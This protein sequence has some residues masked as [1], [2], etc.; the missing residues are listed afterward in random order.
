[1]R[2][3]V[4]WLLSTAHRGG[5]AVRLPHLD[6]RTGGHRAGT[7]GRQPGDREHHD[8]LGGSV[9]GG[10]GRS[11]RAPVDRHRRGGPDPLGPRPG[12]DHR[13]TAGHD[14]RRRGRAV[15]RPATART[16]QIN[17]YALPIL[18]QETLDAQ[19]A[20]IDMV[21]GATVTSDGYLAVAAERARPGRRCDRDRRRGRPRLRRA[22]DGHADQPGPA[23]PARRRRARRG[24]LGRGDGRAAR[25][26][27]RV[28]HLPADS[29]ISRL[30]RG[31]LALD[32][33]PPE[34]GEVLALGELAERESARRLR[35]RDRGRR[36]RPERR[37][38][39]LGRRAGRRP[40]ARAARHR[41]LPVRRRRPD[42]AARR[43]RP[44]RRGASASRTRTTRRGGRG[45]PSAPAP[46]R[47]PGPPTAAPTSS[48][49][50]PAAP[51][52]RVRDRGRRR[53]TSADIDATAAFALG[54]DAAHW[55]AHPTPAGTGLVVWADGT[56][57]LVGL[58]RL[59]AVAVALGR[60]SLL[61]G[62]LGGRA[63][64]G[65]LPRLCSAQWPRSHRPARCH[66]SR[67][68]GV[69]GCRSRPRER[70]RLVPGPP[71][72]D[73]DARRSCCRATA[74]RP[75]PSGEKK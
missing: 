45:R 71:A 27:P 47:R 59:P 43:S 4:L 13:R 56:T 61:A 57:E 14:H 65:E 28:Q 15:P 16:Q 48:M 70:P 74:R 32:D 75:N 35:R 6:V 54:R 72:H 17:A 68:R 52:G 9:T 50:A 26:R 33:C 30:G 20:D 63:D 31:E 2:R 7:G 69:S 25:R 40:P 8:H 62:D 73:L 21:S 44:P 1:M 23:R 5:A 41:L 67:Q 24:R 36:A 3:I 37:G 58:G 22:R 66:E 53:L 42:S 19:S 49:P 10:T 29:V 38:Q 64:S 55:L 46:S 12:P 39:G 11:R 60:V 18:V 34:V 51:T